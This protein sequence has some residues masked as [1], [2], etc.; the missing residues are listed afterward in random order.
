VGEGG[1]RE[2]IKEFGNRTEVLFNKP[3]NEDAR[4]RSFFPLVPFFPSFPSTS[5]LLLSS[6]SS[7]FFVYFFFFFLLY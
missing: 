7:C 6:S 2:R 3:S 1:K 4:A 5:S